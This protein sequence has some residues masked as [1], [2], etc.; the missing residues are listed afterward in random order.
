MQYQDMRRAVAL[1]YNAK[2]DIAPKVTSV[3]A[4][5]IAEK[6]IKLAIEN[7]IPIYKDPALVRQLSRINYLEEIPDELF[8]AV[9]EILAFIYT[10][11][12]I[13]DF[14]EEELE[15]EFA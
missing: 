13:A 9:A 12:D 3:G 10:I 7:N 2:D 4:G 14:D 15:V 8:P 11:D 5:G 6:I 1:K